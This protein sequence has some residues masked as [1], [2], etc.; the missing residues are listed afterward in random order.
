MPELKIA[1]AWSGR[2]SYLDAQVIQVYRDS[3]LP[4][5]GSA[6]N[7][8]PS[9]LFLYARVAESVRNLGF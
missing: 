5:H 1:L 2:V 4:Q 7:T 8:S 6:V 3:P 9:H